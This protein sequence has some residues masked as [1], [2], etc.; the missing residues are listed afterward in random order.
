M[1]NTLAVK[2]GHRLVY[3]LSTF[4]VCA[5][6]S[7]DFLSVSHPLDVHIVHLERAQSK[8][9]FY[10]R[11]PYISGIW[12]GCTTVVGVLVL[13]NLPSGVVHR[14]HL[15]ALWRPLSSRYTCKQIALFDVELCT[16][17]IV[18]SVHERG[19][20]SVIWNFALMAGITL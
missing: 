2:Y 17:A 6:S 9:C 10:P 12:D 16:H 20:R 11:L 8:P 4:L 19:S 14:Y 18:Q 3:L 13:R 7:S 15:A 1:Q 5:H